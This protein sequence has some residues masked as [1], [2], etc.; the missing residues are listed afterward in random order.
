[1]VKEWRIV[2]KIPR[3][4]VMAGEFKRSMAEYNILCDAEA[5]HIVFSSG[6]PVD[7]IT[8]D[9]GDTVQ[10]FKDANRPYADGSS[11]AKFIARFHGDASSQLSPEEVASLKEVLTA[12]KPPESKTPPKAAKT[13]TFQKKWEQAEGSGMLGA[14]K[15]ETGF[16]MSGDGAEQGYLDGVVLRSFKQGSSGTEARGTPGYRIDCRVLGAAA[17]FD[18]L[19]VTC[20][21]RPAGK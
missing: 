16:N 5:A 6:I 8:W 21:H 12:Y 14:R 4:V 3:I 20:S 10:W 2:A 19:T 18:P 7:V 13:Y 15:A 9:T 17:A 11:F 1:M